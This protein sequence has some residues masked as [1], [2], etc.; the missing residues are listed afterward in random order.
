MKKIIIT[1][2]LF[3]FLFVGAAYG[4]EQGDFQDVMNRIEE[5]AARIQED[6]RERIGDNLGQR[7]REMRQEAEQEGEE[8][9]KEV[10]EMAMQRA[11]ELREEREERVEEAK[12]RFNELADQASSEA[13]RFRGVPENLDKFN[14]RATDK[15]A[16][17]LEDVESLIADLEGQD[18]SEEE[19]EE[20]DNLKEEATSLWEEIPERG[21]KSYFEELG[22]S[23]DFRAGI[24]NSLESFIDDHVG[25]REAV[26]NLKER[27]QELKADEEVETAEDE[28]GEN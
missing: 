8:F 24:F 20:L 10:R 16:Q 11:E 14:E 17:R 12:N 21:A 6:V 28:N 1:T 15:H 27:A 18:L 4:Q 9:G 22:D 2:L 19:R 7:V 23:E 5:S 25:L 3:S 26:E 13:Q